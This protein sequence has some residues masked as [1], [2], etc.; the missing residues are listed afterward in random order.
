MRVHCLLGTVVCHCCC[1]KTPTTKTPGSFRLKHLGRS[2]SGQNQSPTGNICLHSLLCY[3]QR[4]LQLRCAVL[5][6]RGHM[7]DLDHA[8]HIPACWGDGDLEYVAYCI[9]VGGVT[10]VLR[11][12]SAVTSPTPSW[13]AGELYGILRYPCG[14]SGGAVSCQMDIARQRVAL[15]RVQEGSIWVLVYL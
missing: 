5:Q 14:S 4:Y 2:T 6:G 3:L 1:I 11:V 15:S 9:C 13:T 12:M 10:T 8:G 7:C